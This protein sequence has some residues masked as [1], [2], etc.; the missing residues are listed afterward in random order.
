MRGIFRPAGLRLRATR[1]AL[2]AAAFALAL[3]PR[4]GAAAEPF[5]INAIASL[6]GSAAFSG[7]STVRTLTILEK[8]VNAGGGIGGRPLHFVVS[9]DQSSPQVAVQIVTGLVAKHVAAFLG[10]GLAATCRASLPLLDNGPVMYCTSPVLY[11]PAGS[12]AFVGGASS[13]D[14]TSVLLRYVVLTRGL[15]RI[16]LIMPTDATGQ[17]ADNTFNLLLAR[18]EYRDVEVTDHEHFGMSDISVA[19][20]VARIKQSNPQ[21]VFAWGT[22]APVGN[23]YRALQDAGLDVPVFGSNG[24]QVYAAMEQWRAILPHQYYQYALKWP[25]YAQLSAGPIKD[26]MAV[27]YSAMKK[28]GVRPDG[29]SVSSWDPAMILIDAFRKL[30]TNATAKQVRDYILSLRDFSGSDGYYDFRIGNQRGLSEKD[31]IV[32]RW[33]ASKQTWLPV[34]GVAAK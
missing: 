17:E 26:A 15:K 32:V 14:E 11:P 2:V 33:D 30:G 27:M 8:L 3:L 20:Q 7:V 12:Y 22:G 34:T 23:V 18:P 31:C 21:A 16:A 4:G 28:D 24:N 10:P 6:T 13:V 25:A 9:D 1:A 29:A 5:E 19:A